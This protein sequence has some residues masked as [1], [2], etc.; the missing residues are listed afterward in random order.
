MRIA[1]RLLC[2]VLIAAALA[3]C[4][5]QLTCGLGTHQEGN[6][7]V[8][9]GV[10][11][12]AARVAGPDASSSAPPT[13]PDA[14][15][16]PLD[17][18][19][20]RADGGSIRPD[21]AWSPGDGGF[22]LRC[23]DGMGCPASML[24]QDD[25]CVPAPSPCG[26]DL[27]CPG[28]LYCDHGACVI[29]CDA[30][31]FCPPDKVCVGRRCVAPPATCLCD[32]DCP[33]VGDGNT[34]SNGTCVA[35]CSHTCACRTGFACQGGLCVPHSGSD[36]TSDEVCNCAAFAAARDAEHCFGGSCGRPCS[37]AC[38]CSDGAAC[39]GG[40]CLMPP[41]NCTSDSECPCSQGTPL[42]CVMGICLKACATTCDCPPPQTGNFDTV[43]V[44]GFC[45]IAPYVCAGDG[46]CP[47]TDGHA[48]H[49]SQGACGYGACTANCDCPAGMIC[50]S[51]A[52][53]PRPSNGSFCNGDEDCLC[54]QPCVD[55]GNPIKFCGCTQASHCP[56]GQVCDM[57]TRTCKA[58]PASYGSDAACGVCDDG[59]PMVCHSD[60]STTDDD[61]Q[62][63]CDAP[64]ATNLDCM[65]VNFGDGVC[66]DGR[67]TVNPPDA[68]TG[69][70]KTDDCPALLYTPAGGVYAPTCQGGECLPPSCASN[71]DCPE[72]WPSPHVCRSGVCVKQ[73]DKCTTVDDCACTNSGQVACNAGGVCGPNAW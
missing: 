27:E 3:A 35:S 15:L 31:S 59:T 17:A 70:Q 60:L 34:C 46:D 54:G 63:H 22:S 72:Q 33:F 12:D 64:C 38:Q 5:Q 10:S 69:C 16:E 73:P 32:G 20:G 4:P 45:Q 43:C 6:A 1:A 50:T 25:R 56:F 53:Q 48:S 18:G 71:C 36:C 8:A 66:I 61:M 39:L 51:G 7:C 49:C 29:Q 41:S 37:D 58:P 67:C 2:L 21:A 42:T 9:D 65:V 14:S 28:G 40:H 24:C 30:S 23:T 44:E 68:T 13:V 57:P 11:G 26:S 55:Q 19:V 52:C 47:C 62:S